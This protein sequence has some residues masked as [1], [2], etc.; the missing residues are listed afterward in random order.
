MHLHAT[1]H[2]DEG[3]PLGIFAQCFEGVHDIPR[4]PVT[5][6]IDDRIDT[7]LNHLLDQPCRVFGLCR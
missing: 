2:T 7:P 4:G 3:Y 6:G 5:T 1:R